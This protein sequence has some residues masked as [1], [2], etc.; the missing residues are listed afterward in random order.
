MRIL[1]FNQIDSTQKKA[2][3][4]A[5]KGEKSWTVILAKEQTAGIGRKGNFW[6]SPQ[7]GLYFSVILPKSKIE[8]VYLLNVFAAFI[9]AKIIKEDFNLET[10]I[11]LPN[12][13]WI[14]GKK[15]AGVLTE[16]IIIG[17]KIKFSIIGI[18]VNTN[19]NKFPL[20]LQN[21][22]TSLKIELGRK[23]NNEKICKSILKEIKKTYAF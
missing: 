17:D 22:A 19:I 16:N 8:N 10:F 15:V 1:K 3:E 13:V 18:G 7:G 21:L 14:K 5:Q 2:K 12:D 4:L 9:V 20:S 23:I 6:Y 11:K